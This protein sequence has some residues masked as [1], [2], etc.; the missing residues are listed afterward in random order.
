MIDF[1]YHL[2]SLI[3]VFL[4]L[5]VG[6]VLGAGPLRESLGTQLAG[7]VEQLRTDKETLRTEND[8]LT[9]QNDQLGTYIAQTAPQLVAG[10]LSGRSVAIVTDS[11]STRAGLD[12]TTSLITAAGGT[13]PVRVTLGEV[14]WDPAGA[15]ARRAAVTAL[16]TAAPDLEVV[17]EDDGERLAGAVS[18]LLV[19]SPDRLPAEQRAAALEALA[20]ARVVT[21]DGQLPGPVDALVYGGAAPDDLT[22]SSDTTADAATR[23]QA[24][25]AAQTGLLEVLVAADVPTVVAGATPG[26]DDAL[27]IIRLARGG[28]R[29]DAL[30]TVDGLQRPDGPPVVVLALGEQVQGGA[31]DYGT[32]AG[33]RAR[34]PAGL[35]GAGPS[36]GGGQG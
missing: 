22:D 4:A 18:T 25:N 10:T 5:A 36:D 13:V 8:R 6:I 11:A 26:S 30:S 33:A 23:A 16:R 14:L 7:Q 3:S 15:E 20:S 17:G 12:Q 31:G 19:A 34:I 27:G 21:V 1:R 32:A 9:A 29:F 28:A 35:T 2:V 24:L